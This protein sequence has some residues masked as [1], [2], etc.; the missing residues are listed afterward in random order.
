MHRF[1]KLFRVCRGISESTLPDCGLGIPLRYNLSCLLEYRHSTSYDIR[2]KNKQAA[3]SACHMSTPGRAHIFVNRYDPLDAG[4]LL[5]S[6]CFHF[7]NRMI[8][9][10]INQF[11]R[12]SYI[13]CEAT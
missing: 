3:R 2:I 6:V 1:G 9:A 5:G 4:R 8:D 7:V 12:F 10:E 13:P 11:T